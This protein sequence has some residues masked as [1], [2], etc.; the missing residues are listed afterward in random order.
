M[1]K[2]VQGGGGGFLRFNF[3][4]SSEIK[5]LHYHKKEHP[6]ANKNHYHMFIFD[7][8]YPNYDKT[9]NPP[10]TFQ[11][12]IFRKVLG[13]ELFY[14]NQLLFRTKQPYIVNYA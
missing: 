4:W 8:S 7:N 14:F 12:G 9:R 10:I 2:K 11:G 5:K 1:G 3:F 13:V 6:F